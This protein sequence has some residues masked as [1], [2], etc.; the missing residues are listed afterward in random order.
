MEKAVLQNIQSNA[1][2]HYFDL[3]EQPH[4]FETYDAVEKGFCRAFH[5]F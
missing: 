2:M 4:E 1:K 3:P 5:A